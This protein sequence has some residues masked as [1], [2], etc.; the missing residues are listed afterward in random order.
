M[1]ILPGSPGRRGPVHHEPVEAHNRA[2][3]VFLTVCTKDRK[4]LLASPECHEILTHW[5]RKSTYW[6]AGKYIILP[7]HLHLFCAPGTEDQSLHRWVAYWKNMVARELN[8]GPE[9]FWQRDFWD[10]QMRTS[11]S[12]GAQWEYIRQNPVRHGLTDSAHAWPYQGEINV[13]DWVDA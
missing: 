4:P 3:I 11:E 5:W 13:L 9:P 2:V 12:Y 6:L 10:V 7:D 8:T 1:S